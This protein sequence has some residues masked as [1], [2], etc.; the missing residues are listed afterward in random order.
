[1][2]VNHW[3][4]LGWL[5]IFVICLIKI[6]L[7]F[8][9][10]IRCLLKRFHWINLDC[11]W[12]WLY[13]VCVSVWLWFGCII[14]TYLSRQINDN[15]IFPTLPP[16]VLS[17]ISFNV[18]HKYKKLIILLFIS[19][20]GNL[21]LLFFFCFSPF[22]VFTMIWM[23]FLWPLCW[24]RETS[25]ANPFQSIYTPMIRLVHAKGLNMLLCVCR[26]KVYHWFSH[27]FNNIAG[28]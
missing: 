20:V 19:V 6:V 9:F 3:A 5:W 23:W 11:I 17:T 21:V 26:Q 2:F 12:R 8:S 27:W 24:F 15:L 16:L 25:E 18:T 28:D 1:M 22:F 7:N 10:W 4:K 14:S 13:N